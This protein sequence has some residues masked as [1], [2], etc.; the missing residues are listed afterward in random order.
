MIMITWKVNCMHCCGIT[1]WVLSEC[2]VCIIT[3]KPKRTSVTSELH[4]N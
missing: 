1:N 2:V 4:G 3:D